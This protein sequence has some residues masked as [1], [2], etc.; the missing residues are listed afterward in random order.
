MKLKLG[1]KIFMSPIKSEKNHIYSTKLL[2][3]ILLF[4]VE[5]KELVFAYLEAIH[6]YCQILILKFTV[7]V[8]DQNLKYDAFAAEYNDNFMIFN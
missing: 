3:Q 5:Y 7:H 6:F 8:Y 2:L 4:F 1:S